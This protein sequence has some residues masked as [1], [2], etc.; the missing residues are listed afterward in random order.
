MV[1]PSTYRTTKYDKKIIGRV[2]PGQSGR[3]GAAI[4]KQVEIENIIKPLIGFDINLP[5]YIIF[6]KELYKLRMT[7][8]AD[9]VANEVCIL[10]DKWKSRGLAEATLREVEAAMNCPVCGAV[11]PPPPDWC[12]DAWNYRKKITMD[13][14]LVPNTTQTDFPVLI[15]ITDADLSA[16]AKADGSDICFYL[17][18]CAQKLKREIEYWDKATGVL[19]VWVKIPSLSHLVD[20]DIDM[21]YGNAAGAETN[22]TAT[23]NN[24]FVMVQHMTDD[25]DNATTQDS[26]SYD[27][28][29]A[30]IGAGNPGEVNGKIYKAQEFNGSTSVITV[31]DDTELRLTSVGTVEAWIKVTGTTDWRVM[32]GKISGTSGAASELD[33]MIQLDNTNAKLRGFIG[34]GAGTNVQTGTVDVV[35]GSWHHVAFTWDGSKLRIYND[36]NFDT[37]LDQTVNAQSTNHPV[38]I[39]KYHTTYYYTGDIDEVRLSNTA[40]SGDWLKT[41]HNNQNNPGDFYTV[42][43]EESSP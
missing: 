13:H 3:F 24:N 10:E 14:T 28:D 39:G 41:S 37:D 4:G 23:W 2:L 12:A 6:G 18:G 29:G 33:Y 27:N 26:T 20:T 7:H 22:D 16:R 34:N 17:T 31:T 42:G 38:L 11:P 35:D 40:R 30:K 19:V 8:G 43:A 9:I 32:V 1:R 21:Y 5:Y 15:D 25:P 36:G